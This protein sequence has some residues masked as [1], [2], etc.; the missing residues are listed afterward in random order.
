M[1]SAVS[2]GS[3][4]EAPAVAVEPVAVLTAEDIG[5]QWV[6]QCPSLLE[7]AARSG[8]GDTIRKTM[9]AYRQRYPQCLMWQYHVADGLWNAYPLFIQNR[10][11]QALSRGL[12]VVDVEIEGVPGPLHLMSREHRVGS[13]VRRIRCQLQTIIRYRAGDEWCATSNPNAVGDWSTAHVL[14]PPS[15]VAAAS[16]HREALSVLLQEGAVDPALWMP[17]CKDE[18]CRQW[19]LTPGQ[20]GW[21]EKVLNEFFATCFD[22]DQAAVGDMASLAGLP[23][24]AEPATPGPGLVGEASRFNDGLA[25]P[26]SKTANSVYYHADYR[27]D[28]GTLAYCMALP[29][30]PL[31]LAFAL[32]AVLRMCAE[33]VMKVHELNRQRVTLSGVHILPVYVYTY[34]LPKDGDQ[35]Y[36]AM[37]CAMRNDDRQAIEFWRPLI[38]LLDRALLML[39]PSPGKV[40]TRGRRGAGGGAVAGPRSIATLGKGALEPVSQTPPPNGGPRAECTNRGLGNWLCARA[41]AC[42]CVCVCVCAIKAKRVMPVGTPGYTYVFVFEGGNPPHIGTL[43][44][45]AGGGGGCAQC[46]VWGRGAG[47]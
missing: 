21:F 5:L 24:A 38:W 18:G 31:G 28:K 42:V 19:A 13:T 20:H 1:H 39:P 41:R 45:W 8:D 37:N 7:A 27:Y 4:V 2:L 16:P 36:R 9:A 17:P 33:A 23:P 44:V 12:D 30:N 43:C 29:P 47:V 34:E 26:R 32:P 3:D 22:F 15:A 10:V 6:P 11:C 40:C 46:G 35:I 25:V 14:S